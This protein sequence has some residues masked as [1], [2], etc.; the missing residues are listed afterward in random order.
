MGRRGPPPRPSLQLIREGN[1]GHQSHARLEGGLRLRPQAPVE[2]D[3]D[4]WFPGCDEPMARCRKV[5]GEEWHR[6]V[7]VLDAQGLLTSLDTLLLVDFC[8]VAARVDQCERDLSTNGV[9]VEGR[10]GRCRNPCTTVLGQLRGQ[11]RWY[12]GQLGLSPVARDQLSSGAPNS[13]DEDSPFC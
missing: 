10:Q 2:P 4:E 7:G 8:R 1:P 9:C 6:V 13:D 5:A 11:L 3:W 12:M